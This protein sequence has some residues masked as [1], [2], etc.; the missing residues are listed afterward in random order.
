MA[1]RDVAREKRDF[2]RRIKE[3]RIGDVTAQYD[4]ALMYA[5]GV[6]VAKSP[7][8]ALVWTQA[9]AD[10]GHVSA[11]YLLGRALQQGLGTAKDLP[12]ALTCYLRAAEQGN[13]KASLK[14]SALHAQAQPELSVHYVRTAAQRGGAPAQFALGQAFAQGQGVAPDSQEAARW[15][16]LA[17]Q[18]GLASAQYALA[19]LL[20]VAAATEADNHDAL[21][22]YR[23]AAAQGMPAAALALSRLDAAGLARRDEGSAPA[24]RARA[25]ERRS[26]D[27]RWVQF[28][29]RGDRDDAYHLG[30]MFVQGVGLER[31]PK[32]ARRWLQK[33][34]EQGHVQSMEALARLSEEGTP[35]QA[36]D[37]YT[38]AAEAGDASAQRALGQA[39]L[40]AAVDGD[41][42]L[43]PLY[44]L[45]SAA[46]Q[47]DAPAQ[48]TLSEMLRDPA[49]QL[50]LALER[51]AAHA[52]LADAQYTMGKRSADGQD[53][54][55][56]WHQACRW[57]L[58]AAEQSHAQAQCEL[59]VCFAE[60]MGV[61]RDIAKAFAWFEKSAAQGVARAQ[62]NLGELYATGIAGVPADTRKATAL[63]KRAA[64]A[65]FVPAQATLGALFARA[66]KYDR[67]VHWWDLAAQKNDPEALFN[68]AQVYRKGMGVPTDAQKANHYL[69]AA[70]EAGLAVAQARLGVAYGMGDDMVQDGIEAGKWLILAARQGE[71]TAR[72]NR[73]HARTLVSPAQWTEAQ[74]RADAWREAPAK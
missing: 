67:A 43:Q 4:V 5:N 40:A 19:Q 62:W 49:C 68:L 17:A 65:G 9:A 69:L 58:L 28:A 56:D 14:L 48:W 34:A 25:R 71:P 37:W 23:E 15:F 1:E 16:R 32:Q 31:S 36:L 21:Y 46:R 12:R 39:Q 8:Q 44:W 74:R 50:T 54:P 10:K 13:D 64:H 18:Q 35:E 3:A 41:D 11:L 66:K 73:D 51:A 72:A 45:A 29:G 27:A 60:G 70:A 6:G 33:A 57:F 53:L 7:E 61:R 47:N 24:N 55:Q 59:A 30:L 38:R 42:L 63:C 20:E 52:G 2:Q 22:W 26:Q